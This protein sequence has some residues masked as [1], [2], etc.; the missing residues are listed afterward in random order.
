VARAGT[1]VAV[2]SEWPAPF[3]SVSPPPPPVG[4]PPPTPPPARTRRSRLDYFLAGGIVVGLMVTVVIVAVIVLAAQNACAC[5]STPSPSPTATQIAAASPTPTSARPT[6]TPTPTTSL[7]ASGGPSVGPTQTPLGSG[8]PLATVPPDIAAQIDAVVAQMPAIRQLEPLRDVP[9]FMISREQFQTDLADMFDQEYDPALFDAQ[10]RLLKRLG[11]LPADADLRQLVLDLNGGAVAAFYRPDTGAF[12]VI[13]RSQ[14][15][16]VL[17]RVYVAHE[18]T[19][20]LQDQHFD[21]EG[22]RITDP[23]E[24]DATLAQLAVIEG[25][26]T[27]AMII[28]ARENLTFEEL[29]EML[30]SSLNGTDQQTLDNMPLILSRQLTFPYDDGL[31]FVMGIQGLQG[32]G[33]I[34]DALQHPPASTEQILHPEKYASHEAPIA[35][36]LNDPSKDLGI[37]WKQAWV[38]TFGELNMQ[39]FAAGDDRPAPTVPGLPAGQWPHAEVAAGWGGDRIYMWEG[40]DDAW[41]IGWMTAWDTPADAD[42]FVARAAELKSRF[43]GPTEISMIKPG[44]ARILIASDAGTLQQLA[45]AEGS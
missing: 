30:S 10:G 25:D 4:P 14:P 45:A 36:A 1:I 7:S 26:A 42:E 5:A 44:V 21:L 2:S 13:Q 3:Q 27:D 29:I 19:H 31:N 15:F 16:G 22:T 41:G 32:W 11:L 6:Q 37:G 43:G 24:G 39:I 40:P 28:W 18:Y 35:V 33:P 23:A 38:D 9:Y 34:N 20:A 12:Y 8:E 17:D